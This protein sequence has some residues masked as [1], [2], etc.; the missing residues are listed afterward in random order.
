MSRVSLVSCLSLLA[1][2]TVCL[3]L[4]G[5]AHFPLDTNYSGPIPL[6]ESTLATYAYAKYQGSYASEILKQK[7]RYTLKRVSFPSNHN[8]LPLEHDITIDYYAI[9]SKEKVPVVLVLPILGGGNSIASGFARYFA[10]KGIAAAVVHRQKTYRKDGYMQMI[11]KVLQQ[12]VFDHKQAIDWI[13]SRPELDAERIG[14]FGVSMG[15]IK[16]ALISALDQRI[17]ASVIALGGGDIPYILT[18]SD[19]KRIKSKR[20]RIMTDSGQ[21]L[22]EFERDLLAKIEW[23][24]INYA[25]HIDAARTLM[26]LA[27]FDNVVP[28][29]SGR[30]LKKQIGHPETVYLLSGHYSSILYLPYVKYVSWKFLQKHLM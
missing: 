23:D 27:R 28:Y 14:V 11:N 29:R 16:A 25:K 9:N 2:I 12:I 17:V 26:V 13:E 24:P 22:D 18:Y 1:R 4:V 15:G 20:K 5:C 30:A 21:T 7:S 19:E 8:I 10:K 3:S 6:S